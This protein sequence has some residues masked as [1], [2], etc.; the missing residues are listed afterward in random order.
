MKNDKEQKKQVTV[1]GGGAAGMTAAIFAAR[2]LGGHHVRIIE[3]NDKLGR[4]LLAT[5]NGRC[6]LTN[7]FCGDAPFFLE[8]KAFHQMDVSST[9][10]FFR[11]LGI[12]TREESE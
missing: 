11:K 8:S 3:K 6:N 5:G 10:E 7:R 2:I 9:L 12:I 4:K 1:I